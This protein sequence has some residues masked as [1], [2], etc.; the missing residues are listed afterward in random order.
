MYRGALA[1]MAVAVAVVIA[2]VVLVPWDWS[3]R[4]LSTPPLALVGR[5]S[6]GTTCGTG[7]CSSR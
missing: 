1:V 6:Y 5:I 2:H 3:A 7:R 4:S